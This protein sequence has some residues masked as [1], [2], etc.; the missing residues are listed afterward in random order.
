MR[1]AAP[2]NY[3]IC[4]KLIQSWETLFTLGNFL[5]ACVGL[6][7]MFSDERIVF[8]V[9]LFLAASLASFADAISLSKCIQIYIYH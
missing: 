9:T 5:V 3:I 2:L 6:G 8:P 4:I 1:N 7:Y